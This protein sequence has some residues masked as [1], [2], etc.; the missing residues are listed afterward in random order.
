MGRMWKPRL[1]RWRLEGLRRINEASKAAAQMAGPIVDH[2]RRNNLARLSML[3]IA[4]G[5][6]D[7][8][9]GIASLARQAGIEVDLTLL[10]RSATA[11]A[12]AAAAAERRRIR[13]PLHSGRLD[14]S[15]DRLHFRRG[16]VQSFSASYFRTG[17]GR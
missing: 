16:D 1:M 6:G 8:P 12:L 13:L 15:L 9:V 14:G 4:C 3:D 17:A 7:V 5:G 11:L 2:A 10:D